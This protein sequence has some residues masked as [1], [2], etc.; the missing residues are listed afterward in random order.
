VKLLH[1]LTPLFICGLLTAPQASA[2]PWYRVEMMLVAYENQDDID[3]ELWPDVLPSM[4]EPENRALPDYQWWQA[5]AMYRQL[6]SALY[7]GFSFPQIPV[8]ELPAPFTELDHH[9]LHSAETRINSRKDMHVVW[10]QAWI[11][12]IQEEGEAV[13]HPVN[14]RYEGSIAVEISGTFELHRSRYLH[15]NTDLIVQHYSLDDNPA[16]RTLTLPDSKQVKQDDLSLTSSEAP[17]EASPAELMP[18][19]LRAA[20]VKLSRR[21]RSS[22]LHYV[23]HPMLGIVIKILP[24]EDA[25]ELASEASK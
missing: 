3:H 18:T 22:E 23:D 19:P 8:A 9:I 21:M 6:H 15:L 12:P 17:L 2:A 4:L 5:P 7:A 24:L 1:S 10:H 20:E 25:S 16:L 13:I 14:L 11:E